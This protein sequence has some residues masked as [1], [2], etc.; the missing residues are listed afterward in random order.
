MREPFSIGDRI[1]LRPLAA[2]D[3]ATFLPWVNDRAVTRTLKFIRPVSL[4]AEEETLECFGRSESDVVLAIIRR[5]DDA[6][7]GAVGLHRIHPVNRSAMFGLM[8]GDRA[9]WSQGFGTEATRL[10][11]DYA[12]RALN[13]HRVWLHVYEN[14]PAAVRVYEKVGFRREGILRQDVYREGRYWDALAMGLLRDEW[15]AR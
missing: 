6:L 12:F 8:I 5:D 10:M 7:I 11:V 1:Y 13:L 15:D 14:N 2:A 9:A 4:A 3:A